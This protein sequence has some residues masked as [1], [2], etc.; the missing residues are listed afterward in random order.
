MTQKVA[1]LCDGKACKDCNGLSKYC[2][3]TTDVSHAVNFN[4]VEPDRYMEVPTPLGI[5]LRPEAFKNRMLTLS[6]IGD[7]ERMHQLMDDMMCDV[8]RSLG[9]DEGVRIFLDT[10][11]WYA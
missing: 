3:H 2:A 4:E 5:A 8:L 11:K 7:E 1:Y 6:T 9:Y 10:P